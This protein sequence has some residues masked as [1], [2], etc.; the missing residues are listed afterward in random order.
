MRLAYRA[1]ALAPSASSRGNGQLLTS[2]CIGVEDQPRTGC[3]LPEYKE[4]YLRG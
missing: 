4:P 2:L 3:G 1:L